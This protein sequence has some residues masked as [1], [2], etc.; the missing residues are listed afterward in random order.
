MC[1]IVDANEAHEFFQDP[2]SPRYAPVVT[3]ITRGA[4]FL[5]YGGR[6]KA[7]LLR[8]SISARLLQ[9]WSAAGRALD[10]GDEIVAAEE[11]RVAAMGLC[12]S[13]D[14]HIIA[15][16]RVS[17]ARLLCTSD[18]ALAADFRNKRLVDRPRGSIYKD[19]SHK[20]LLRHSSS[21]GMKGVARR[22]RRPG[23]HADQ[24]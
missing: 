21:C 11:Q 14:H 2:P 15:L 4:G 3:W 24:R 8:N 6:L 1:V 19:P 7:E 17:G 22:T 23:R 13:N 18:D 20:H 5:R 10:E 12:R 16:A 9:A